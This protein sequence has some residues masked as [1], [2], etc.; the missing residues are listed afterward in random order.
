MQRARLVPELYCTDFQRSLRFY[1]EVL[2]FEVAYERPEERFAYLEREGAEIM[3]EQPR[4]RTL[5][6]GEPRHPF[7]RGVNLQV[8]VSNVDRLYE[9]V[10]SAGA[11]VLLDME[12]KWY[13]V[14]DSLTG[15]RQ[16]VVQDPDG[17]LLRFFGDLGS[18]G[19][20]AP[21]DG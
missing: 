20:G 10:Q 5:L 19:I 3:L 17:Y 18:R 1:T 7:G 11:T 9:G 21:S 2:G 12:E 13:R 14:G 6:A 15:N 16:F 4:G 8:Q